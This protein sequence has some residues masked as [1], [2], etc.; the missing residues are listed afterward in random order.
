M[1][2]VVVSDT[3]ADLPPELAS[4]LGIELIPLKVHFGEEE[5]RDREEIT[6]EAFYQKLSASS[7]LPTTSQPSPGEFAELYRRLAQE[8]Q[9]IVSVHIS[10]ALSGTYQSAVMAQSMVP[11]ARVSVV[12]SQGASMAHGLQ[13]VE[14]AR[15]AREGKSREELVELL[16]DRRKRMRV[17]FVVDTLEYLEKGGRIGKAQALLGSM[18]NIKPILY[19]EQGVVTSAGKAR[20]RAKAWRQML[21]LLQQ[22]IGE[23][24]QPLMTMVH[25]ENRQGLE[26]L[27]EEV[28]KRWAIE[29]LLVS[30]IGPVVGTHTGPGT[31]AVAAYAP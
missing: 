7:V 8:G 23:G 31:L 26:L 10:A 25:A 3:T 13:V 9:E 17:F 29:E 11:E 15:A 30:T 14:A 27:E 1:G 18:L 22:E 21:D 6:A 20:G 4:D 24:P 19:L 5:Y 16:E 12:D 2:V 28:R